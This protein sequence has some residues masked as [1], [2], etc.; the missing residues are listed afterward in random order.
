[1]KIYCSHS[2]KKFYKASNFYRCPSCSSNWYGNDRTPIIIIGYTE[3][4]EVDENYLER[5]EREDLSKKKFVRCIVCKD[6]LEKR[7]HIKCT[8]KV[9]WEHFYTNHT[10]FVQNI[11]IVLKGFKRDK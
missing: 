5:I 9:Y 2:L 8:L 6:L 3:P 4:Y 11:L 10:E 7:K 1:M